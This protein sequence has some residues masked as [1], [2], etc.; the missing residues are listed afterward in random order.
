MGSFT[1]F[2]EFRDFGTLGGRIIHLSPLHALLKV[3]PPALGGTPPNYR[4]SLNPSFRSPEPPE[5]PKLLTPQQW[6]LR[7][8]GCV[9]I[10]VQRKVHI[11]QLKVLASKSICV[12]TSIYIYINTYAH[13][14]VS[15][16]KWRKRQE[17]LQQWPLTR[18]MSRVSCNQKPIMSC[19]H[20]ASGSM[21]PYDYLV[22]ATGTGNS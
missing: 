21:L 22:V 7:S 18:S 4:T 17:S 9:C 1:G 13:R 20:L 11:T 8:L 15:L 14:S 16:H 5:V 19:R 12:V 3:L 6:R 2:K 10:N